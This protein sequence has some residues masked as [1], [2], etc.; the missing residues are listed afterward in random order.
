MLFAYAAQRMPLSIIG[1]MQY[2]V[3]SMNFLIGWQLYDEPLSATKLFG[4]ALV[5]LGLAVLTADSLRR[6]RRT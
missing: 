2:I 5:W 3:P 1:P 6:A 4:F